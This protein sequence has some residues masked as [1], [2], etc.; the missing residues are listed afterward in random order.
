MVLGGSPSAWTKGARAGIS[1]GILGLSAVDPEAVW[2]K[3]KE[4]T[5]NGRCEGEGIHCIWNLD[6]KVLLNETQID[7]S[8]I[9]FF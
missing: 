3:E 4:P 2:A 6:V 7:V 5:G 9:S 8:S 1:R